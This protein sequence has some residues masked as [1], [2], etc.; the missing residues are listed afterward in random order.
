MQC[1]LEGVNMV[2]NKRVGIHLRHPGSLVGMINRALELQIPFF[3]CFFVLQETSKLINPSDQE[4]AEFVRLREQHFKQLYLH[5]S[6]WIN[7]A[8]IKHNGYHSF[9]REIRLAR[10]LSFTHMVLHSG[11]ARGARNRIDGIDHLV[12]LLNQ[13]LKEEQEIILVLENTTHGKFTIGSDLEDFRLV[14]AKI[15]RP[16]RIKFCIDTAHAH[17]FGYK[18]I[19]PQEQDQFVALI[20]SKIGVDNVVL[21]HVNDSKYG[22]GSK[23]DCHMIPGNGTIGFDALHRFVSHPSLNT[24]PLILEPPVL[25]DEEERAILEIM[26]AW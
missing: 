4:I 5:G 14:L 19:T 18:L 7:L 11:S 20:D 23:L 22:V 24:V 21:L 13:V 17:A 15:E 26:R 6:Y 1:R 25:S 2:S 16:E 3:Q 10:A 8:G 9:Q 12:R